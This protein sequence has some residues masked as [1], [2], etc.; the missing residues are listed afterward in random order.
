MEHRPSIVDIAVSTARIWS[1]RSEDF[2]Q[3]VGACI[4]NEEGRVLS[5]G[6]NGLTKKLN[7]DK[8]FWEDRD[9]RRSYVIHA[10]MNALSLIKKQ[11]DPYLIAVTLLPCYHCAL[12]ISCYGI[13]NVVYINDYERDQKAKDIFKFY[14]INLHKYEK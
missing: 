9:Q 2:Y 12:N 4:L 8:S 1:S 11:D 7:K 3:K 13:K 6:Y 10:E 14:N 5:V